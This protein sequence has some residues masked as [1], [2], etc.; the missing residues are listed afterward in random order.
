[1]NKRW[2]HSRTLWVNVLLVVALIVE[3]KFGEV[4][5][6]EMQLSILGGVNLVLRILTN[7]GL[8]K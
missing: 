6:P 4:L 3:A 2:F 8:T 1:M 7:Q 5:T